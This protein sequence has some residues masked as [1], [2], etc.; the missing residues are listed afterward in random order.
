V[1]A[2]AMPAAATAPMPHI[3]IARV[4]LLFMEISFRGG[5]IDGSMRRPPGP[6]SLRP[7]VEVVP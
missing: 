6:P 7:R 4:I 2:L 1:A 5:L 3:S